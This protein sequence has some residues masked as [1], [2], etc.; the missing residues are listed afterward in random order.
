[1]TRQQLINLQIGDIGEFTR[2]YNKGR[3]CEVVYIDYEYGTICVRS[4]DG[5]P[6]T[7]SRGTN[8]MIE[9][10]EWRT[11]QLLTED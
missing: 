7:S 10:V 3:K 5:K 1:M 11:L 8:R 9:L 6:F 2:G 4:I